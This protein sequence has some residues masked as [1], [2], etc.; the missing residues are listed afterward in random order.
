MLPALAG[1]G[2]SLPLPADGLTCTIGRMTEHD[3]GYKRLF[4]NKQMVADLIRGFV[5]EPWV[6]ELDMDTLERISGSFVSDDFKKRENDLI[7][8]VKFEDRWLYVYLLIEFQ[9]SVDR[10]MAL[11]LMVYVGLLY[12]HLLR[13]KQVPG[14]H[15]LPPVLPLVLYNGAQPWSAPRDMADLIVSGPDELRRYRPQMRY[16]LLEEQSLEPVALAGMENLVAIVFRLE[17]CGTKEEIEQVFEALAEWAAKQEYGQVVKMIAEWLTQ[18]VLPQ[19]LPDDAIPRVNELREY[20]AMLKE[21]VKEWERIARE[22]G[23]Q[24]GIEQG[25]ERG[26]T[27]ILLLQLQRKFGTLSEEIQ[28]RI[29]RADSKQL[30]AWGERILTAERI[31]ELFN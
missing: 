24:E 29:G 20:G 13:E 7:W 3:A 1:P 19:R 9:S 31:D 22:E 10:F 5:K 15:L 8:R 11:R 27:K 25:I 18:I 26:E 28:Q 23:L 4:S 21:T 17:Q 12:Q 16:L 6:E 14:D 30:L 2:T